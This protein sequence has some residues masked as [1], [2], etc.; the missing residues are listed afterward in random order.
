[1]TQIREIRYNA[2]VQTSFFQ[3][4]SMAFEIYWFTN[5]IYIVQ[6]TWIKN[7]DTVFV[8][9]GYTIGDRINQINGRTDIADPFHKVIGDD[10]KKTAS[11]SKRD[12]SSDSVWT[13]CKTNKI[14]PILHW[15]R[16]IA[17]D[18][19]SAIQNRNSLFPEKIRPILPHHR[20][21]PRPRW[22]FYDW[23][24]V[25]WFWAR[26]TGR[27]SACFRKPRCPSASSPNSTRSYH[28]PVEK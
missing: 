6:C 9:L 12:R 11:S 16:W 15:S 3:Y 10:L 24:P 20:P 8:F 4:H 2:I 28:G 13:I 14:N 27:F 26:R 17:Y 21:R 19:T 23:N 22:V 5:K 1:M 18:D 25:A 7:F